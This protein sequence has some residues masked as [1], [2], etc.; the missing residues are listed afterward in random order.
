MTL[1]TKILLIIIAII[2]IVV[3][4]TIGT[5]LYF[6]RSGI[7]KIIIGDITMIRDITH[8][9]MSSEISLIK[10]KATAS[11]NRLKSS[12]MDRW[13]AIL[14][15]EVDSSDIFKSITIFERNGLMVASYGHPQTPQDMLYSDFSKKVFNGTPL[16]S[17][18]SRDPATG[19]MIFHVWVP[20]A[21]MI[22]VATIPGMYFTQMLEKFRVWNSGSVFIIDNEGTIIADKRHYFVLN[23]YNCL[24]DP[25]QDRDT[26]SMQ[27]FTRRM[28]RNND[29]TGRY[30]LEGVDHLAVF[31]H[32]AASDSG[33]ILGVSAPIKENPAAFIDRILMVM[34]F[35]FL[36]MGILMAYF[37]SSF[38]DK[39]FK[40]INE[41]YSHMTK[42]S[43]IAQNASE[44]KTNFL[45]KMS[46]EM[47]T[48]LNAIIGFSELIINGRTDMADREADTI[49]IHQAG[50]T[51]L[52]LVNDILDISKIESGKFELV[53]DEYDVTSVVNDA[54][55]VNLP[56]IGGKPIR[57][58][59]S[60]DPALPSRLYG[61]DLRVK[62]IMTNILSNAF[63]Y[64]MEG[65]V[66]LSISGWRDEKYFWL[67]IKVADT[68]IGIRQED[69]AKLF[70]D[71]NQID[72]RINKAIEGTGLGLSITKRLVD[73]MGGTIQVESR[74][75]KGSTFTV[76]IR[77]GYVT[78]IPIG[79]SVARSL[80]NRQLSRV[81]DRARE[82][83][84]VTPIP[85]ASILVVDDVPANLDV[86]RGIL[87]P[88]G[89]SL[90]CATS[91]REAVEL[92]R[93]MENHYDAIFM[94][95]MMPDMDGV[96]TLKAIRALPGDYAKEVPIIALTA[97]ALVENEQ[98]LL[99]CGFQAFMSKP[100]DLQRLD[101]I[102]RQWVQNKDREALYKAQLEAQAKE[103][104]RVVKDALATTPDERVEWAAALAA[105]KA[106]GR[107]ASEVSSGFKMTRDVSDFNLSK[108]VGFPSKPQ[109]PQASDPA[110]S[111][112]GDPAAPPSP[113][114]AAAKV[115]ASA[116]NL[117]GLGQGS[118]NL[119]DSSQ[120]SQNF[121][122]LSQDA[123]DLLKFGQSP[124]RQLGLSQV[125]PG[126][127]DRE[128]SSRGY[129]A[130][131]QESG[132]GPEQSEGRQVEGSPAAA[133]RPGASQA[134]MLLSG[135]GRP[136][137]DIV[138]DTATVDKAAME[139]VG[140]DLAEG[141]RRFSGDRQVYFEVLRS[142][143]DSI[144][145]LINQLSNPTLENLKNYTIVIH[146]LKSSSYGIC[147]KGIGQ[148]AEMLELRA[149]D[150]DLDFVI[151]NNPSFLYAVD[152]MM[153]SLGRFFDLVWKKRQNKP[154]KAAP[155]PQ[156][157]NRL[158]E[159]CRAYDMDGVDSAISELDD[160]RYQGDPRLTDWLKDRAEIM[161]FQGILERFP[162]S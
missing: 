71:Y 141:L 93:S 94:D 83:L 30:F 70:A 5:S 112:A 22:L 104:E 35:V 73:L 148:L 113:A 18:T 50:L 61:D 144:S 17:T 146:G 162:P 28:L 69:Q 124:E 133:S 67:S 23:R 29:G 98:K 52:S 21:Q 3:A 121:A 65:S 80:E 81:K 87:K 49:K 77:Q 57:F 48:P 74:H 118:Q 85:Y 76:T 158:R 137:H 38:V 68:G 88:Y 12:P 126:G 32:I 132:S 42:L 143:R 99:S 96:E 127:D 129:P 117:S 8:E 43:A 101:A 161:D 34:T 102:L 59:L 103:V 150:G 100:V 26:L 11:A 108:L 7:E 4:T 63:K 56:R 106:S 156:I 9:L 145:D 82:R 31:V 91:G 147:A 107:K 72:T 84:P 139:V 79:E 155:D 24:R 15:E 134:P 157:L 37:A 142:Y 14:K 115:M 44:A 135:D 111:G 119:S 41:Q 46:H 13:N 105:A 154:Q 27:T 160:Y 159:A 92:I 20:L 25:N 40:T 75:G 122:S 152:N 151:A 109:K 97:N 64:T 51:L 130:K 60:V 86:I 55:T 131:P 78:D 47:R 66:D 2:A 116:Q 90:D 114:L 16:I 33:W 125:P 1:R 110:K 138:V 58:E 54:V 39:Q 120:N 53:S 45:A 136:T 89:I 95:Q 10:S 149:A 19:E 128:N 140:I 6:M 153:A 123:Q 62:Q 36:I